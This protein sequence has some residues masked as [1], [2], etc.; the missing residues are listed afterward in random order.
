[1]KRFNYILAATLFI[2]AQLTVA[3]V[4]AQ[5]SD[6]E[7]E[8]SRWGIS[9]FGGYT[10]P[11]TDD[12][13]QIFSSSFNV[14]TESSWNFGGGL[15]YDVTPLWTVEGGY[16]YNTITGVGFE[17]VIHTASFKNR[18]NLDRLFR[19]SSLSEYFN[20]YVFLGFEQD[21][22]TVDAEDDEFSRNESSV[23]GGFGAAFKITNRLDI[24]GQYDFKVASNRLDN[25]NQGFPYDQIGMVTGGVRINFGRS[26]SGPLRRAPAT[27]S[28]S[29]AEYID[30]RTKA[31]AFE[32]TER[33]V[34]GQQ[35]QIIALETGLAELEQNHQ[36]QINRLDER[37]NDLETRVA[38]LE[39]KVDTLET[40]HVAEREPE[41]PDTV[42]AGHYV[43]VFASTGGVSAAMVR[44][45]FQE[46]LPDEDV[47]IIS[48]GQYYEVLI[49]GFDA[50]VDAQRIHEMAVEEFSDAFVITFPRPLSL[51]EQYEGTEI[52]HDM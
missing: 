33:E 38:L 17:T 43:Q 19:R 24:F 47:F 10:F 9:L 21:F 23:V 2:C 14:V 51:E 41:M 44:D 11:E 3:D 45:R 1:M 36:E 6:T 35:E 42:P 8:Y 49:G 31:R 37:V 4:F 25:A 46:M 50:F 12:G 48:R 30:Y 18:L 29:D 16:R 34:T 27:R 52:R 7:P 26:G 15:H 28:L 40:A 32:E 22:F 5:E 39:E 20:P 13:L